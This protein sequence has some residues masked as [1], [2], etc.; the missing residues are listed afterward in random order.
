[1]RCPRCNSE[2]YVRDGV[3]QGKQRYYCKHCQYRYRVKA[4]GKSQS[5]KRQAIELY[6]EGLGFRSIERLLGISNVTIMR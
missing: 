2:S 3:V 5:Q 6:L 4:R 1:M